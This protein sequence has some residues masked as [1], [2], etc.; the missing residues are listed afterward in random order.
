M[1]EHHEMRRVGRPTAESLRT[2]GR[3][4]KAHENG[5]YTY[6]SVDVWHVGRPTNEWRIYTD[7]HGIEHVI[8]EPGK[9]AS[10]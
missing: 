4:D 1:S 10:P 8:P 7:Q 2:S 9:S 5:E 3:L 6:T